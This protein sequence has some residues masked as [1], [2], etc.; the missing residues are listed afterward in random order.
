MIPYL[1]LSAGLWFIGM[2]LM[3][4]SLNNDPEYLK[5]RYQK[6]ET[7]QVG[8]IIFVTLPLICLLIM[9]TILGRI[10]LL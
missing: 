3:M 9:F 4:K 1:T 7:Y 6:K 5:R 2:T 10:G 8:C